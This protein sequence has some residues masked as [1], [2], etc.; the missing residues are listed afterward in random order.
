M[1]RARGLGALVSMYG[2]VQRNGLFLFS[3][4]PYNVRWNENKRLNNE[5][6]LL[7]GVYFVQN[8]VVSCNSIM[9]STSLLVFKADLE[10]WCLVALLLYRDIT[11]TLYSYIL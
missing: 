7:D 6:V 4:C 8:Y 3:Q 1:I 5:S 10:L 2:K 9:I 11:I